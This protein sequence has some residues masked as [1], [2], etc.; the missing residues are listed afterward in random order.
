MLS[1]YTQLTEHIMLK[2]EDQ[3][4]QISELNYIKCEFEQKL[5]ES[6]SVILTLENET[7]T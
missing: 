6:N 4:S 5:L 3:L 1:H 2:T 7:K